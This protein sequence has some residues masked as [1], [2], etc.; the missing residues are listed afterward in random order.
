MIGRLPTPAIFFSGGAAAV[1]QNRF[2]GWG[3]AFSHFMGSGI[4]IGGLGLVMNR[5][6]D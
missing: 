6:K 5:G 3:N 2:L 1:L 4:F